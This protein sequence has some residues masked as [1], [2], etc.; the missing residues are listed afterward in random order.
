MP[1]KISDPRPVFPFLDPF[2]PETWL[3]YFTISSKRFS[4]LYLIP[5]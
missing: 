3:L 5:L 1:P 2:V 4:L